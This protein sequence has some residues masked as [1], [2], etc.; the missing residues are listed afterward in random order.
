MSGKR[1]TVGKTFLVAGVLCV[2]CSILVSMAAVL[3]RPTQEAN[4]ALDKKKNIL[5]AA[6]LLEEGV[7]VEK[8]F[9]EKIR[10]RAVNLDSGEY[11]EDIDAA[12]YEQRK[13]ASDPKRSEKIPNDRDIARIKRT[14]KVASVYEV[15]EGNELKQ[16]IL[17]VHGKGLWSTMYGFLAIASDTTTVVGLGF[18]EHAETPG[19]GGEIDNPKWK[20]SWVGKKLYDDNWNLVFSVLKG[21]VQESNP[22]AIHQVDGLSGA[23]LTANGVHAMVRFWLGPDGFQDYLIKVREKGNL[24]G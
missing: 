20:A 9:A 16:V 5:A 13:A 8:V 6:G 15:M 22:N 10:V 3:L 24:N 23:T 12:K 4:K 19:L 1:E 14:A 17:P 2:V 18:Y 7:D 21:Q 11:A